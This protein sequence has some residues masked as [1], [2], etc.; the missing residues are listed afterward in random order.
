MP[1]VNALD[2][3]DPIDCEA[4]LPPAASDCAARRRLTK[5]VCC[6]VMICELHE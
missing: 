4:L 5:S 1:R 6:H 2:P 3:S